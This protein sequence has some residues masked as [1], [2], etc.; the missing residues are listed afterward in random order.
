MALDTDDEAGNNPAMEADGLPQPPALVLLDDI[1]LLR[2]DGPDVIG[3]LQ[4]Y[5]T[6]DATE[7]GDDPKFTAMCNIRGRAVCTGYAWLDGQAVTLALHRSLC[8]TVRDFL[9][10]YMMF[11]KT[12]LSDETPTA[13]VFGALGCDGQAFPGLASPARRLDD[14][15]Q[16]FVLP[17]NALRPDDLGVDAATD[18]ARRARWDLALIERREVWLAADTTGE[19]LPQMIGLDEIGAVS[20]SKGCYL[21]QEVVA[22]AEH[23]GQVKRKL[24]AL[25]W[26]GASPSPGTDV[27]ANGRR[28][29]T[30]VAVA[31][32]ADVGRALAVLRVGFP[33]PFF[34]PHS[35]TSFGLSK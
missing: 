31:G 15:R 5:L 26:S 35:A 28:I 25:D 2:F 24:T 32:S 14:A 27:E 6:S 12:R 21:G 7:L 13:A 19:F 33:G 8:A 17:R 23:L 30:V 11:S 22:R 29:G 1:G 18:V 4:G 34:S 3:F 9:R 20:F 10:P 16:L